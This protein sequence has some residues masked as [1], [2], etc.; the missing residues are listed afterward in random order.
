MALLSVLILG[1]IVINL[2]PAEP[3]ASLTAR[4][5]AALL[6]YF[7]G[8]YV[9]SAF[10]LAVF[11][12]G[13]ASG[14][15]RCPLLAGVGYVWVLLELVMLAM[16]PSPPHRYYLLEGGYALWIGGGLAIFASE[17]APARFLPDRP[18]KR[19]TDA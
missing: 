7:V 15:S 11:L 2:P 1:L 18:I 14:V 16:S 4:V 6:S 10:I 13:A 12:V 19:D 9:R 17:F 8:D 5:G 3:G